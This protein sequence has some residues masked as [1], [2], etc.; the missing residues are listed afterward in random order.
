MKG[1]ER[2]MKDKL[3]EMKGNERTWTKMKDKL[4]EMK[5]NQKEHEKDMKGND[6]K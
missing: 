3:N 1:N 4:K 6:K 5:A 2:K